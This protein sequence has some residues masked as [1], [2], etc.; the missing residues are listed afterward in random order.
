MDDVR[1]YIVLYLLSILSFVGFLSIM[2]VHYTKKNRKYYLL[3]KTCTSSI[4]V[5]TA[6]YTMRQDFNL[7]WFLAFLLCF[8]GDIFLG[9]DEGG[10]KKTTNFLFGVVSF[11]TAHLLFIPVLWNISPFV[12]T[13]LFFPIFMSVFVFFLTKT[14]FMD[15]RGNDLACIIYAFIVSSLLVKGIGVYRVDPSYVFLMIG[16][17]CFFISDFILF[18]Q[19]FFIK[20]I[21]CLKFFNLLTYYAATMLLAMTTFA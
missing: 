9:I 8:I 15:T 18:F 12:F 19:Y 6:L 13:D 1:G 2:F 10:N 5:I 3:C 20:E 14:R 16:T 4:F 21:R 7:L 17:L 11:A